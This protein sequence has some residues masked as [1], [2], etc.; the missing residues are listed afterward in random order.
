MQP[1][2]DTR[3][4][5]ECRLQRLQVRHVT[6][7]GVKA[8]P[9]TKG[10]EPGTLVKFWHRVPRVMHRCSKHQTLIYKP[11]SGACIARHALDHVVVIPLSRQCSSPGMMPIHDSLEL[12]VTRMTTE[13]GC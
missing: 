9:S 5:L 4:S 10:F 2:A 3:V 11:Y 7:L 6:G 8:M 13:G 1:G 12:C